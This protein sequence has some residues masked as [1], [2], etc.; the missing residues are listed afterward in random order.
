MNQHLSTVA[1]PA[2]AGAADSLSIPAKSI[3]TAASPAEAKNAA[4]VDVKASSL[5]KKAVAKKAAARKAA[6][7]GKTSPAKK[8]VA[9]RTASKVNAQASAVSPK[10]PAASKPAKKAAKSRP[11]LVRDSFTMPEADFDLIAALKA[12]ALDARR[13]AKK[14]ELLRAGLRL[15]SGL[16]AKALV[17]ALDKLAPVKVGRP[18]KGH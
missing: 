6:S 11:Q 2:N 18:K 7:T 3:G 10:S 16:E 12:K 4:V 9:A 14:S 13:A 17:A 5:A 1:P 15:L 8:V